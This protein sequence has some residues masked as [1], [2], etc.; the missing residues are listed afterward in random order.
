[1]LRPFG[2]I[3]LFINLIVNYGVSP[4]TILRNRSLLLESSKIRE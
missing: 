3:F 1:M 2:R 4:A